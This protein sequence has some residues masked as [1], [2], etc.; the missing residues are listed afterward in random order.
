MCHTF[1]SVILPFST[2]LKTTAFTKRALE[3]VEEEIFKKRRKDEEFT[4]VA[5][6]TKTHSRCEN[7][8]TAIPIKYMGGSPVVLSECDK[9]GEIE[10]LAPDWEYLV[11]DVLCDDRFDSQTDN[12]PLSILTEIRWS[13]DELG[14]VCASVMDSK[15]TAE[16]TR[17][18]CCFEQE[19]SV[20]NYS[21]VNYNDSPPEA[22]AEGFAEG[23]EG[24]QEL[25]LDAFKWEQY[26]ES[27][28]DDFT[29]CTHGSVPKNE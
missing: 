16:H 14:F 7:R 3:G 25:E 19:R 10:V 18:Q 11:E 24:G 4:S 6:D 15:I 9:E 26:V 13:T 5:E 29:C 22:L 20:T 17:Q 23:I 28:C 12:E 2:M 27:L 1:F 21:A 8:Q